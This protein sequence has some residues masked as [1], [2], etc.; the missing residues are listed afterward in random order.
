MIY[1]SLSIIPL[2]NRNQKPVLKINLKQKMTRSTS[3]LLWILKWTWKWILMS[4]RWEWGLQWQLL[5]LNHLKKIL[6]ILRKVRFLTKE[7]FWW[8]K[9]TSFNCSYIKK[10]KRRP[11]QPTNL[12]DQFQ[13]W[14]NYAKKI[15]L[16][17]QELK[18]S[19]T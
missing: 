2:N 9:Q 8:R 4:R 1:T 16:V 18:K 17:L 3:R 12:L 10:R 19:N 7:N 14:I 6:K 5:S 13:I 11:F 15:Q